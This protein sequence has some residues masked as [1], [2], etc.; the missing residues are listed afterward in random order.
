MGRWFD[1]RGIYNHCTLWVLTVKTIDAEGLQQRRRAEIEQ[2]A[3]GNES[4]G[5]GEP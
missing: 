1:W 5:E 3:T 2:P 4:L